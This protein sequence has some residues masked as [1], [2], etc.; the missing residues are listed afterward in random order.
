MAEANIQLFSTVLANA[1]RAQGASPATVEKFAARIAHVSWP[2]AV[3]IAQ[4]EFGLKKVPYWDWDAPRTREGFYRYQGGTQCAVNR[5]IAFAPYADLLWM[6]TKKPILSQAREFALGV[7]QAYPEQWLAYNLSPSFNWEAAGLNAKDM[8]DYVWELGKL[9][10]VWQFITVRIS[11]SVH[12]D[13]CTHRHMTARRPALQR[14]HLRPLRQVLRHRGHEGVR[15]DRTAPRAR[16][17]LRR[18][19]APEMVRRRLHGQPHEDRHRRCLID[20]G[21]G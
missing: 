4:K 5:A 20:C 9:G 1:L 8:K 21:H 13:R 7:H 12:K 11:Y 6:E 17:R 10:F 16:D 15:R 14:L 19:H 18:P 3:A 2:T